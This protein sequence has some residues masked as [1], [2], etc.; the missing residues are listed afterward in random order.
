MMNTLFAV[1]T[2]LAFSF[3]GLSCLFSDRSIDEFRRFG[4]TAGQRVSVGIL[5]LLGAIGLFIGLFD[6]P[7]GVLAAAGLSL[8]MLLGFSVRTKV[9]DGF[10]ASFASF[11]FMLLNAYLSYQFY[12]SL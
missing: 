10:K 2:S 8:L 5:Q 4:L 7:I 1:A 3:Y 9:K 11:F 6:E 12:Q